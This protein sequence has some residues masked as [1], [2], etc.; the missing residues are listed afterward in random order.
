MIA[1]VS[2]PGVQIQFCQSARPSSRCRSGRSDAE[3]SADR[4]D[5]EHLLA[6]STR[7]RDPNVTETRV[8]GGV[9][10]G[11]AERD[12]CPTLMVERDVL[13]PSFRSQVR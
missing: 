3:H 2:P 4:K 8:D 1:L 9:P 11:F 5:L 7:N 12:E 10:R 6:M 13:P